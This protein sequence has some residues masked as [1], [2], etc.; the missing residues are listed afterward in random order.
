MTRRDD[1]SPTQLRFSSTKDCPRLPTGGFTI[2]RWLGLLLLALA[3]GA[4]SL[5]ARGGDKEYRNVKFTLLVILASEKPGPSDPSLKAI[6]DEIVK[7]NP[8]FKSFQLKTIKTQSV[9][10]LKETVLD[11]VDGNK[12]TFVIKHGADASNKVSLS[13][14]APTLDLIEYKTVCGKFLPI[15]TRYET[16]SKERLILAVR[17]QPCK[18]D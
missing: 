10:P 17:V 6:A 18:G 2:M 5:P 9:P 15:V 3:L 1:D 13:I 11:T 8:N 4:S 14:T 12:V 7:L 16:K